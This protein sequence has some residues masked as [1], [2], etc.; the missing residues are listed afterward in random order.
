[1]IV[2]LCED[3]ESPEQRR[4]SRTEDDKDTAARER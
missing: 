2:A 3:K 1:V 4:T